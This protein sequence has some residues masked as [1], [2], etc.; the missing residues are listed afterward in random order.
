[1]RWPRGRYNGQRIKGFQVLARIDVLDFGFHF[2]NRYG[3]CL[4]VGW[5]KVWFEAC[6]EYAIPAE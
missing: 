4:Q 6:Y 2:P 1:M 5:L 3:S